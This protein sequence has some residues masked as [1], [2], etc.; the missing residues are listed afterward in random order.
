MKFLWISFFLVLSC[1]EAHHFDERYIHTD[2]QEW[3]DY[4][5]E[6]GF[7][8]LYLNDTVLLIIDSILCQPSE[9]E[10]K[11]WNN[12]YNKTDKNVYLI[13]VEKHMAT[14]NYLLTYFD[15]NFP[16]MQDYDVLIFDRNLI[17]FT[18]LKIYFNSNSKIEQIH[19]IGS[20]SWRGDFIKSQ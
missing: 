10:L 4:L 3:Y 6:I 11:Y 2:S 17:P 12:I 20:N 9:E 15:F 8:D 16:T 1:T 13:I 19:T 18:P 5:S 14:A 7:T